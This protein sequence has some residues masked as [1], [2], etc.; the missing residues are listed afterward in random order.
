MTTVITR[1]APA[2]RRYD[3]VEPGT[4]LPGRTVTVQRGDLVRYGGASCDYN[5]IHWDERTAEAIGLPHPIAHG[6][7]TMALALSVVSDWAGDPAAVVDFGG[8]FPRLVPVPNDG[9]GVLLEV[10]AVVV[11]KLEAPNVRVSVAVRLDGAKVL[12]MPRTIVA[13]A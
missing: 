12:T 7:F 1:P 9:K 13:L 10:E 3:D 5:T 4:R 2:R 6:M 11:E 8:R